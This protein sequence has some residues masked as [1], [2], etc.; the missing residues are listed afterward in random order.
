MDFEVRNLSQKWFSGATPVNY[1]ENA[2]AT[3]GSGTDGTVTITCD[4]MTTTD[5]VAITIAAEISSDLSV[6]YADGEISIVLGT[7]ADG[8]ADDTKN[9]AKLIATEISKIDGYT[10]NESGTGATAIS[11]AT[12]EDIEFTNGQFGTPC[13]QAGICFV[14]GSTYYVATKADNSVYNTGWRTFTLTD[15]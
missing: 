14:S 8:D 13:S 4:E 15:Y 2:I 10:A 5:V 3:I 11:T 12:T 1:K 9:T 7:D 6:T